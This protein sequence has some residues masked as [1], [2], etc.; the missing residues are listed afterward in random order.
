MKVFSTPHEM[1]TWSREER[2][3]GRT[4]A[5]VPT[6]GALHE[7][8]LELIR[9][10]RQK[11]DRLIVSIYVNPKQFGPTED[12]SRYPRDIEGDLKKAKSENVDAVFL[13]SDATMY[14]EGYQ[15]YVEVRDITQ[16]LCGVSRP[17]HFRGVTTVVAKLFNITIPDIAIFGEKDFQQLVT[18]R[19][20]VN[21]LNIPIEIIGRPIVREP[22]GLAMSSRNRYLSAN[23]RE[24][25]LSLSQ[26]LI[27]AKKLIE[28]GENNSSK[29]FAHVSN[30][31][32][33]AKIVKIDYLHVVNVETLEDIDK[34]KPPAL[35]A[36]A[37]FVGKTRLIDNVII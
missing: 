24:A 16:R 6:M 25:A 12:L 19:R 2:R 15:T 34:I 14:P 29:V 7:G 36:I 26:S 32:D 27:E 4:I 35:I 28:E 22:D 37:A 33:A 18:I 21:D 11:C 20:M 30:I 31:I 9:Y 1:Y 10:G 8:H 23:E 13:P 3:M 17:G 5:F